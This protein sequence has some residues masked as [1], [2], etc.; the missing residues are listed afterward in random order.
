[1][2]QSTWKEFVEQ[3]RQWMADKREELGRLH[4]IEDI[5][6]V[7]D[8]LLEKADIPLETAS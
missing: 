8:L 6:R 5:R 3:L 7:P 4:N 2:P 1:M